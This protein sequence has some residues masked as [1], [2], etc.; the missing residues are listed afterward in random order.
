MELDFGYGGWRLGRGIE[1]NL[2]W[3]TSLHKALQ[4]LARDSQ[5]K[6]NGKAADYEGRG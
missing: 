5:F 2:T 6:V 3:T 1:F 4:T